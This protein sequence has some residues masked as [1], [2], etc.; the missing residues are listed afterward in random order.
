M[1][2][3]DL[4]S[5]DWCNLVFESKNKEY[6]AFTLRYYSSRRHMIA[7]VIA[8]ALFFSLVYSPDIVKDVIKPKKSVDTSIRQLDLINLNKP[9]ENKADE[10]KQMEEE[11]HKVLRNTIKFTPPVIKKDEQVKEEQE[12]KTQS[13]VIDTKAAISTVNYDKGTND[14]S[15]EMPTTDQ[16]ISGEG[17]D[18]QPFRVV[19][20]QPQFPGGMEAL[21]KYMQTHTNYP[22]IARRNNISGRVYVQ[23]VVGREGKI[24]DVKVLKG[25]DASLDTEAIRMISG[26]PD[27]IPGK[28]NGKAVAVYFVLPVVFILND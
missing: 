26:M 25:V 19:E 14:V 2:K 7:L 16:Q 6:G 17:S 9:K 28:Q 3:L 8:S 22:P 24:K 10:I 11:Q 4:Y 21:Y 12:L 18:D 15:A 13:E 1:A 5:Y 27:W 20:Q 23:F